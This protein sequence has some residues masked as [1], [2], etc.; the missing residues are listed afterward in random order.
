MPRQLQTNKSRSSMLHP[1]TSKNK[2]MRCISTPLISLLR[3]VP[4]MSV[5]L[6]RYRVSDRSNPASPIMP[7]D[8]PLGEVIE[9]FLASKSNRSPAYLGKLNADMRLFQSHFGAD[10]SIDRIRSDEIEDFLD[11]KKAASRRRNNMRSKIFTL[12]RC[13]PA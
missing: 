9:K 2:K 11:S 4:A 10:R 8:M 13:T 5:E 1:A 12:F 6:F 3:A 7:K